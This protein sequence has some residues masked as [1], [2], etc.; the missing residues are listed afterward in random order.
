VR[1]RLHHL[2]L[3]APAR[4][5]T[6]LVRYIA[7]RDR[8]AS[9]IVGRYIEASSHRIRAARPFLRPL[10]AAGQH[11]DVLSIFN[12]LNHKYFGGTVD[13]LV[14]WGRVGARR[15][16]ARRT[17]KLGSYSAVERL[18]RVHPTLDRGWIPRYFVS[19]IVYHEMLHHVIPAEVAGSR[20]ILHPRKFHDREHL[21]RDYDRALAWERKHIHRL[22]RARV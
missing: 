17:L 14:T 12:A 22:L 8:E 9:L 1:A 16:E 15:G 21:F 6:A 20:R 10:H 3:D 18:I 5:K 19:Y 4:V 11:H 13:A 2:F 7:R